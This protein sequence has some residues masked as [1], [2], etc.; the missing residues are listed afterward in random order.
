MEL[1]LSYTAG[2]AAAAGKLAAIL[3]VHRVRCAPAT[4]FVAGRIAE[5]EREDLLPAIDAAGDL[6]DVNTATYRHARVLRKPPWSVPQPSD[7]LIAEEI[8]RGAL[9]VREALDRPCRG[10]RPAEGAGAGF[11]GLAANLSAMRD[12]GLR[13]S[14][15]YV[16]STYG[17]TAPGDLC[18]PFRYADDG[19]PDLLELP[20]HGWPDAALKA[21]GGAGAQ[22]RIVRWPS[23][24]AY[25][26][27][28]VETPEEELAVHGATIAAARSAGVPYCCLAFDADST[29]RPQDPEARVIDLL[30]DH[31][32]AEGLALT[33]LDELAGRF[34][35]A[36]PAALATPELPPSRAADFDPGTLFA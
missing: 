12:A 34:A 22:Q 11:R 20:A 35:V 26:D 5:T 33:T 29:V 30:I 16:R 6:A 17:D 18:G 27:G 10:V 31:A 2:T 21:N 3:N 23:P 32:A 13:W 24:F 14:S 9:A 25:P 19:Y 7:R 15:A 4:V 1:V 8:T 28:L 36:D